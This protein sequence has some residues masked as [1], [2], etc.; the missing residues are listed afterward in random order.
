M[1]KPK[2]FVTRKLPAPVEA[3]LRRDYDAV[4]NADDRPLGPAEIVAGCQ[5]AAA[6]LCCIT[7]RIDAAVIAALPASVRIIATFS[8]GFDHIDRAAAAGRG[9]AVTNTP[10]TVTDATVEIAVLCL[11]GAAR[12][13]AE[14]EAMMR[15]GAW[16]GWTPTQLLGT[17]LTGRRLGIVGL[18]RIGQGVARVARSLL[19]EVHYHNRRRLAPADEQGAIH[20]HTLDDL[21]AV[22]DVLSLH[23]PA[24][25]E[26][27]HLLN[28]ATI[29]RLPAGAVVVNTARGDLVDDDDL[30]AALRSGRIAAAGLD[31]YEGEPRVHPGYRDLPNVFLLPHLGTATLATRAAMGF[32]ALD[33]IDAALAG[34]QPLNPV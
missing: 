34:R 17:Q 4:L 18:G 16:T 5:G 1:P 26:T 10:G 23:C 13:A 11:L 32:L 28:A 3:R 20:H 22:S 2:V 15:A 9:I 14:G 31:V 27:R 7:D 12:R 33:N 6:L 8:V 24:S 30:I 29:A 19:M 25:A 21:L